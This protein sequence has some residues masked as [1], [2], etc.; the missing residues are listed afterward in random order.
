MLKHDNFG[1]AILVFGLLASSASAQQT[2]IARTVLQK[3]DYPG[4]TNASM[5]VA[6]EIAPGVKVPLHTHPGIEMSY[7]LEG[8]GVFSVE[9]QPDRHVKAGDSFQV[10]PGKPHSFVNAAS[11]KAV[12]LVLTYVVDKDKPLVTPV[13]PSAP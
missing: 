10:P 12:K 1:I 7:V 9:G 13:K 5:L 4:E 6:V 11:D 3:I 8:D 2:G